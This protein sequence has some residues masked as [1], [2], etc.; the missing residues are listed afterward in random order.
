[1]RYIS[2]DDAKC[3]GNPMRDECDTCLRKTLE[4]HP[5]AVRQTWIGPWVISDEPCP[6]RWAERAEDQTDWSAA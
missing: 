3:V 2:S 4:V 1:M 6:R 5:Q